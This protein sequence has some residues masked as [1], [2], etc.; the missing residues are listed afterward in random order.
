VHSVLRRAKCSVG[1]V[2]APEK[3]TELFA[4][5]RKILVATDGSEFST[6]ALKFVAEQPWPA[7][8]EVKIISVPEFAAWMGDFPS[9]PVGQVEELNKSALDAA[10]AAVT[11]GEELLSKRGWE[12]TTDLVIPDDGPAKTILEEAEKWKA[13]LLVVGSHGRRGFDRFTMGSVSESVAIHAHCSVQ[14]VHARPSQQKHAREEVRDEGQRNHDDC[15]VH[16]P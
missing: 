5:H 6:T 7:G 13:D 16:V 2:R 14:V 9:F 3:V 10:K 4:P 8:T 15:A 11:L 1:V 12:V